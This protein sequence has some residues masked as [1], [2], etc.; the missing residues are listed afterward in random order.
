[1][2]AKAPLLLLGIIDQ[3]EINAYELI[4]V[5]K[6]IKVHEWFRIAESTVY[7]TL[8]KLSKNGLIYGCTVKDNNMPEKIYYNVTEKGKI[9]LF[10]L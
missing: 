9:E 5:L 2:L 8:K 6:N 7:M 3:T 4:K 10:S 1:M